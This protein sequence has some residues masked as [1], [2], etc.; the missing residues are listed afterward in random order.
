VAAEAYEWAEPK[1][2]DVSTMWLD[3]IANLGWGH[4]PTFLAERAQRVLT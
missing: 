2:I 3:M 4:D 1:L